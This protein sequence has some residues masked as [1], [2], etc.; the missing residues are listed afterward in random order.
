[1][2]TGRGHH[3]CLKRNTNKTNR[4]MRHTLL[5]SLLFLLPL[6]VQAQLYDVVVAKD[7][8]GDYTTI[9][10][11]ILSIRD[12][13]PEGRQRILVKKGT[14][15]EK[16]VVPT[17]KTN[18]SLI[19][20]DRDSCILV[21]HDHANLQNTG[22]FDGVVLG[23]KADAM[24]RNK[25]PDYV[26]ERGHRLG[27]FESYSLLVLGDGFEC[28]NMTIANDAMTYYNPGWRE[29]RSNKA[30]VAQAVA[31]HCEAD[32]S[33][34]RN[35]SIL[36]FQDTVF[37]GNGRS[38][39]IFYNCYIEG[40]VDFIFGPATVWMEDCELHSI[41]DGYLIAAST[42]AENPYGYV[43]KHCRVTA[44]P[45]VTG[46]Y[47][48]RPWRNWANVIFMDCEL[49]A[50]MRPQGWHNWN[51]PKRELTARY[52]EY[53]NKGEGARVADRV[54]WSRQLSAAEASVIT[55]DKVMHQAGS[56]WHS[57]VHDVSFDEVVA[58]FL[59][60]KT[61]RTTPYVGGTVEPK[62]LPA[63]LEKD[64]EPLIINLKEVDCTTF[65]EYVTAARLGRLSTLV[66]NDSILQRFVQTLRYRQGKRGNYATR[67]HY[68]SEWINEGEELGLMSDVTRQ[69]S[70]AKPL[71]KKINFMSANPKYYPQLQSDALLAAISDVENNLSMQTNYYIPSALV[72]KASHGM[73]HGDI[74]AFVTDKP[75]LDVQHVGFVY[76]PQGSGNP[77]LL[78]ASSAKGCVTLSDGSLADY[79]KTVKHC[80]GVRIIRLNQ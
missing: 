22:H 80:L 49:P 29:T 50:T 7:G 44:D 62:I 66:A 5:L 70:G 71:K 16:V 78:H 75:G 64:V 27:T 43:F 73:K 34:F 18:I 6:A 59:D 32:R 58:T 67:K 79:A 12:Y 52:A 40:T 13:K 24:G 61:G 63:D 60:L 30:G 28:E 51:D 57:N 41:S 35:C 39:Q 3:R 36:G 72:Q 42:P 15:E 25:Q 33:V 47:L 31:L 69:L 45:K 4:I 56:D 8:T 17:Y 65:V 2:M 54:A 77:R 21:W 9:Q 14:Y 76:D 20:E 68:F 23:S 19:G 53:Q 37:N 55:L 48:G 10:D 26:S 11:A 46:V 1:M 38:R 74:V